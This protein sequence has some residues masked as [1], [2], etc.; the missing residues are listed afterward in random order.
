MLHWHQHVNARGHACY[1]AI[2][3]TTGENMHAALPSIQRRVRTCMLHYHQQ[4]DARE[5]ACYTSISTIMHQDMHGA[6]T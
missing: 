4:N 1:F 2:N 3:T 6:F 5:Y